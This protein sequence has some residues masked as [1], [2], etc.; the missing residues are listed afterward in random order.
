MHSLDPPVI[1]RDLNCDHIYINSGRS[2]DL[3]IGDLWLSSE[4]TNEM[5]NNMSYPS[6]WLLCVATMK[7][8]TDVVLV[9]M[10]KQTPGLRQKRKMEF[11]TPKQTSIH[12]ACVCLKSLLAK[13]RSTHCVE[14]M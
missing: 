14:G 3:R 10:D 2:G 8:G 7:D 6:E 1:H 4:L 9:V 11:V 13:V 5:S 12:T